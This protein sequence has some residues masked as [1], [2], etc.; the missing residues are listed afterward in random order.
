MPDIGRDIGTAID[1]HLKALRHLKRPQTTVA[2][3]ALALGL[4]EPIVEKAFEEFKMTRAK[5]NQRRK[6]S[7]IKSRME[8]SS[9][10]DLKL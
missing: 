2:S 4:P 9:V 8:F 6:L 7:S 1:L 5:I 3:V 10:I